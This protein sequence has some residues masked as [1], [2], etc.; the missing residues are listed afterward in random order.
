[1]TPAEVETLIS[2]GA[3]A[4][5]HIAAWITKSSTLEDAEKLGTAVY[6]AFARHGV[7]PIFQSKALADAAILGAEVEA[8][9]SEDAR[10]PPEDPG[11]LKSK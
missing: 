10:F 11:T 4:V 8:D 6:K 1:M 5:E 7:D 3:I 9:V 2:T